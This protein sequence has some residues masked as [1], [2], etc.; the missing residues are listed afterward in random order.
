MPS[1]TG[2]TNSWRTLDFAPGMGRR[3]GQSWRLYRGLHRHFVVRPIFQA[4]PFAHRR[5]DRQRRAT[6]L[7]FGR[8]ANF[9]NGEL[10]GR[11]TEVSWG[12]LFP[13]APVSRRRCKTSLATL[14]RDTRRVMYFVFVQWRLWKSDVTRRA[15]GD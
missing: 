15:P 7:F 11:T 5:L 12:I 6:G 13:K 10:W 9:I 3:D 14:R 1:S 4:I 8:I 2:G